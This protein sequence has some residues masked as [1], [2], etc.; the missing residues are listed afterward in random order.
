MEFDLATGLLSVQEDFS[1]RLHYV[2]NAEHHRVRPWVQKAFLQRAQAWQRLDDY[3]RQRVRQPRRIMNSTL[4]RHHGNMLGFPPT[5]LNMV[6]RLQR[7]TPLLNFHRQPDELGPELPSDLFGHMDGMPRN[8]VQVFVET[9]QRTPEPVQNPRPT[10]IWVAIKSPL[11]IAAR[12]WES[13]ARGEQPP[14]G[15]NTLAPILENLGPWLRR[16]YHV[17]RR[18]EVPENGSHV[19]KDTSREPGKQSSSNI[20]PM[21][22]VILAWRQKYIWFVW[23]GG[24]GGKLIA[25]YASH[26][27]PIHEVDNSRDLDLEIRSEQ[28]LRRIR[29][30]ELFSETAVGGNDD[31][32]N[33]IP[34]RHDTELYF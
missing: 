11:R 6:A 12:N 5:M 20:E 4:K 22:P 8:G 16:N 17:W 23:K 34:Q 30:Q 33:G 18:L 32:T 13:L 9:F 10:C 15:V 19:V 25:Q 21:P 27:L 31:N 14:P 2:R 28:D 1:E 3:D 29:E 24:A 7:A 26:W